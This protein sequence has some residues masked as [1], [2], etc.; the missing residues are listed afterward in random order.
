MCGRPVIE[1]SL[2]DYLEE[3][4]EEWLKTQVSG[5][6]I[7]Q[8]VHVVKRIHNLLRRKSQPLPPEIAQEIRKSIEQLTRQTLIGPDATGTD[9]S[10][11]VFAVA[12]YLNAL[13]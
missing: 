7:I 11:F 3:W 5:A 9:E 13:K 2:L 6:L 8:R 4:E 1:D 12:T 10:V